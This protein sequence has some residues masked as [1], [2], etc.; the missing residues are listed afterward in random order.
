[1]ALSL[2]LSGGLHSH[3]HRGQVR[4]R[5]PDQQVRGGTREPASAEPED[6]PLRPP[7]RRLLRQGGHRPR[8]PHA[9]PGRAQVGAA[10]VAAPRHRK[11]NTNY[12]HIAVEFVLTTS[13]PIIL[14]NQQCF[15][16]IG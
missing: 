9:R 5:G 6:G 3:P 10:G 15:F 11:S 12:L 4:P 14:S 16:V 8:A 1:M 7:H 13:P 2:S